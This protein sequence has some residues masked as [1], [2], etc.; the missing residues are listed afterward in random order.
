MR[1]LVSNCLLGAPCRYD[2]GAKP[3][4]GVID[5]CSRPGVEV[6]PVCPECLARLPVPRP[7]AEICG[8]RVRL[9]TG[10]DVTEAFCSG[11]R[12]TLEAARQARPHL[13]V[14]KAKSPSCGHGRIYDGTFSGN[15]VAGNGIACDLLVKEGFFVTDEKTVERCH[16]TM[17]HPVA[18]CL[19]SG[20]GS[21]ARH[22]KAVRR[23]PYEDIDG[24][25][26]GA[27]P[28]AGHSFEATVGTLDSVPVVVYPGRVHLYQGYSV[29]EVTSLVRHAHHLGCRDIV[30]AAASGAIDGQAPLGLGLVCDQ[31]NLTGKNPLV[32]DD[33]LRG[34]DNAF[35]D[36]SDAY[37]PYLRQ[38]AK[39]VADDLGV[40]LS[41]GVLAG[42][43][44]PSFESPA[45]ARAMALCGA[46]YTAMSVVN[47]V[48]LAHA[49][50]MNV[51]GVTL[52]AN[53]AGAPGVSHETVLSYAEGH[54]ADFEALLR[55]VL[56]RL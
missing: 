25:P 9:K 6:F 3:V 33:A 51:L 45:E 46:S 53:K 41:E 56:A 23:I 24:F 37:T 50:G 19:G 10:Q 52:S 40:A 2:G 27:R 26:A 14:L 38:V 48:V 12:A 4:C 43:F 42:I 54:E 34:V 29:R 30:F 7:P 1:V 21:V 47:E 13:C 39:A 36:M 28:V 18:I 8:D 22:V 44:G 55:G 32:G 5:L 16:P 20:L 15:L 17:E 31:L 11:A 49:L 35:V